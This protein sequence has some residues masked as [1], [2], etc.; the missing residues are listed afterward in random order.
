MCKARF[1]L[2]R[3]ICTGMHL[4]PVTMVTIIQPSSIS[5]S[6]HYRRRRHRHHLLLLN[7]HQLMVNVSDDV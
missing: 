4:T 2:H 3:Q 1:Q 5:R 6:K 7:R